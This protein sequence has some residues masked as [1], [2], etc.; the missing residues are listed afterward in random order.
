MS[1][2]QYKTTTTSKPF[3]FDNLVTSIP[4]RSVLEENWEAKEINVF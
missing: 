2:N 4:I 3:N 1:Q